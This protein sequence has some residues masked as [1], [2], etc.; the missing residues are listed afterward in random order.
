MFSEVTEGPLQL[1]IIGTQLSSQDNGVS[2]QAVDVFPALCQ[3]GDGQHSLLFVVEDV[4]GYAHYKVRN[5]AT[6]GGHLLGHL[7]CALKELEVA[8]KEDAVGPTSEDVVGTIYKGWTGG[9]TC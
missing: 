9:A 3:G 5:E 8:D 6:L 2:A 4:T 7:P 1:P